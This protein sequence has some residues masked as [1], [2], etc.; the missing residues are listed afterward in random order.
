M[1]SISLMGGLGNQLFQIFS[2]VAYAM[3]HHEKLV[4]AEYKSDGT[5]RPPYWDTLLKRLKDGV[6]SSLKTDTMT[7]VYEEGFHY[8]PLPKKTNVMFIGYFQ[9]YKY[10][11]KQFEAIYK[12][13]NFKMEQELIKNKYLTLNETISLHFR[14]GDYTALQLHHNILKDDYYTDA[15]KEIIKRTKKT[16]WN[17]IYFCEEKD[18]NPVKHRMRKIKKNFPDLNFYKAED[19]MA[20]WEQMLLMSCSDHN[21]IAN[22]AFSWWAAHLNQNKSKV[23]CYP[24]TWFGAANYDKKTIDL[25]PPS[26]VSI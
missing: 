7:K 19:A 1:I 23:V 17:I 15:I 4:F 16:D 2:I 26:W 18:N 9:S 10:F 25:C 6:D 21:I 20:D 5:F 24:K 12:K 22:S 14:I 13:L 11:D 3:E 8:T